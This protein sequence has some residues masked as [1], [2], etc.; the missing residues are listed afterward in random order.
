MKNYAVWIVVA[1]VVVWGGYQLFFVNNKQEE[2]VKSEEESQVSQGDILANELAQQYQAISDWEE[3]IVYT[4]QAQEKLL[5]GVPILFRGHVDDIFNRD[6]K[7]LI[8]FSPD[9]WSPTTY[10][11]ELECDERVVDIILEHAIE[12]SFL[13]SFD[14]FALVA[15]IQEVSKPAFA[16]TG[17]GFSED[18]I[19]VD[20][21]SSN[22]LTMKGSCVDIVSTGNFFD[23]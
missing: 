15:T 1:I 10:A 12:E 19:E 22:L 4:F 5:A 11:L 7:T 14:E 3:D 21:S 20:I 17:S 8:H 16:L 18:E 2:G 6:G 23:E 13:T 9:F